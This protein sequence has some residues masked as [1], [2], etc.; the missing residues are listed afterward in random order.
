VTARIKLLSMWVGPLPKWIDHF[1]AQMGRFRLVDWELIIPPFSKVD[2]YDTQRREQIAWVNQTVGRAL[3]VSCNKD[4]MMPCATCETRP[5]WGEVFKDK[6]CG[7]DY[8]GWS[9]LDLMFGDLDRL[10]PALMDSCDVLN[11]KDRYLSGCFCVMRNTPDVVRAYERG[12]YK[13]I[14]ADERY[15]FWEESGYTHFGL[16]ESFF[17]A[18]FNSDLRI[19]YCPGLYLHDTPETPCP[20]RY[21]GERLIDAKTGREALLLHFMSDTWP[22][23]EDGTSRWL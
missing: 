10:L 7:Y 22:L 4:T 18:I 1:K 12:D 11:L 19:T 16:D 2:E 3:G 14:L 9:D 21:A 5:F 15:H 8:W 13:T 23:K 6:L 17:N 20:T